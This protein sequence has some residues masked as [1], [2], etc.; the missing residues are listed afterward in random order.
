MANTRTRRKTIHSLDLQLTPEQIAQLKPL[1]QDNGVL[2]V[3]YTGATV[4][5][6]RL[7]LSY[8]ACNAWP[9]PQRR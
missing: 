1:L 4:S 3:V 8:V 9:P 5:N 2:K 6:D 7:V